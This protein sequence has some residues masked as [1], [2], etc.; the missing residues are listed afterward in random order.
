MQ[1]GT[2]QSVRMKRIAHRINSIALEG[3]QGI[4]G[5]QKRRRDRYLPELNLEEF[6][7][8]QHLILS[9][10]Q[11]L[12]PWPVDPSHTELSKEGLASESPRA[13]LNS[14]FKHFFLTLTT[15]TGGRER[16]RAYRNIQ[17]K[18]NTAARRRKEKE[19][20]NRKKDGQ[21]RADKR[22]PQGKREAQ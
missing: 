3:K 9:L 22:V 20:E 19:K 15:A 10:L 12:M 6:L 17:Q 7:Q 13:K 18:E 16:V 5:S 8:N 14:E 11:S 4:G 21:G 1:Q 2:F